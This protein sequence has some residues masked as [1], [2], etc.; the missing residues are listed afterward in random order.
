MSD[1]AKELGEK[2]EAK[3]DEIDAAHKSSNEPPEIE[4]DGVFDPEL[5]VSAIFGGLP[6]MLST[7]IGNVLSD[8]L[9]S[10][11]DKPKMEYRVFAFRFDTEAL[12]PEDSTLEDISNRLNRGWELY[13]QIVC[14]PNVML[15]FN[16]ERKTKE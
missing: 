8:Y 9:K 15:I 11:T 4:S 3:F 5:D 7:T 2:I 16:R 13:E 10:L 12:T 6:S 14:P 1:P